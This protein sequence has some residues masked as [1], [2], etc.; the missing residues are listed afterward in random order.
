MSKLT[1]EELLSNLDKILNM[2]S[3]VES[4]DPS[5]FSHYVVNNFEITPDAITVVMTASNRSKQTYYTLQSMLKSKC[6]NL[7]IILVDDSTDDPINI[8][9]LKNYPYYIDFIVINRETKDWANPCVNYNIGFQFIKGKIVVIQNAEVCHVRDPLSNINENI[10]DD[11]YFVFDV[12][13]ASNYDS[14]DEIYN[15]DLTD[16]F[17]CNKPLYNAWYQHSII[18]NRNFHFF[19]AMTRY[20]FSRINGFSYDYSIGIDF[21]DNDLLLKIIS[22]KIN[23]INVSVDINNFCGIHLYHGIS[24]H[25]WGQG[26]NSN[27]QIYNFK[28]AEFDNTQTYIEFV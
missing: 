19:T 24:Y 22:Q 16:I 17:I 4:R 25:T 9:I 12:I 5:M 27:E 13:A 7:Q 15:S 3:R 11:E 26:L 18:N 8:N 6:K 10:K 2:K 28:K 1:V 23:I 20:T 14:N 21:D